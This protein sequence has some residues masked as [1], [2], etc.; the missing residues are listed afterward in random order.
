MVDE[1]K[2]FRED[3]RP[4]RLMMLCL[5]PYVRKDTAMTSFA[6]AKRVVEEHCPD[7]VCLVVHGRG[8]N[9]LYRDARKPEYR[10]GQGREML[11]LQDCQGSNKD[12]RRQHFSRSPKMM[13]AH[14]Q[15]V[16]SVKP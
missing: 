4:G 15:I 3:Q 8:L 13:V 9:A 6:M 14:E 11:T 1:F 7:A 10:E 16:A 5:T 2:T 12:A